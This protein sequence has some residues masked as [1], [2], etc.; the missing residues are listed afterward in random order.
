MESKESGGFADYASALRRR[1]RLAVGLGLPI[2]ILAVIVAIALPSVYRSTGVFKLKDSTDPQ[3]QQ[4][5]NGDSYAD[6][7]ISGLTE[8]VM[9]S[10]NLNS[11]LDKAQPPEG[12][13]RTKAIMQL[14]K[15]IKVDMVTE[16]ILDPESGRE[17][18]IN[19]GFTVSVDSRDPTFAWHAATLATDAFVRASREYALSQSTGE[20]KFFAR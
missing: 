11:I 3:D 4:S 16:K 15:G 8:I 19:S 5:R 20:A 6:R 12:V 18:I 14:A 17:R 10:D 1:R 13:D 9:R 7:Y 2:F